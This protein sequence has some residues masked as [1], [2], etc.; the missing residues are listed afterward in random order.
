MH[1]GAEVHLNQVLPFSSC[2]SLHKLIHPAEVLFSYLQ[3]GDDNNSF[4]IGL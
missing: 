1:F 2:V 4:I 3:S